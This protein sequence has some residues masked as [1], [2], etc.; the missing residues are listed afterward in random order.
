MEQ[1][2]IFRQLAMTAHLNLGIPFPQLILSMV[3]LPAKCWLMANKFFSELLEIRF[4]KTSSPV[5]ANPSQASSGS[6]HCLH[7]KILDRAVAII[8]SR[9]LEDDIKNGTTFTAALASFLQ[10]STLEKRN[11]Q[12]SRGQRASPGQIPQP[13]QKFVG[14]PD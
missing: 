3:T 7:K 5:V 4:F 6:Q 2:S 12:E 13:T 9:I 8:A 1:E 10:N 14:E 11:H